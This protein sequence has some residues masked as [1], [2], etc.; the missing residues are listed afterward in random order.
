MQTAANSHDVTQLLLDWSRG[1]AM[2]LDSLIESVYGELRWRAASLL[3]RER[4]EHTLQPTA[5][6]NEAFLRL[7]DQDRV[8]WRNRAQ[9]FGL[10]AQAMRRVLVDHARRRLSAKRGAG[11]LTVVFDEA[12]GGVSQRGTDLVAL[13]DALEALNKLAPRQSKVVELRYFGGLTIAD[14]AVVLG[15]SPA[16]VKLDWNM[17]KA[18]LYRQMAAD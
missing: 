9:F 10:A 7:V 2:A 8:D 6:V 1:D 16:T 17:A 4:A 5:L 14:A 13:D 18:W 11:A 12:L 3:R 15:V